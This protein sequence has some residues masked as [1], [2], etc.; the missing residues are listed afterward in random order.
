MAGYIGRSSFP[1][2]S[3]GFTS[4]QRF[5]MA[6]TSTHYVR[7]HLPGDELSKQTLN[8]AQVYSERE[9]S[10]MGRRPGC[11]SIGAPRLAAGIHSFCDRGNCPLEKR[12]PIG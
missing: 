4:Q 3:Y 8:G 11:V 1:P 9:V 10:Y 6:S 7:A 2:D 5:I 12:T